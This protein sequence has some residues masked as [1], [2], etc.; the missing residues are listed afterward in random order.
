MTFGTPSVTLKSVSFASCG[1]NH[2][3]NGNIEKP[4]IKA[5]DDYDGNPK[6]SRII[7]ATDCKSATNS[8]GRKIHLAALNPAH[9]R[10]KHKTGNQKQTYADDDPNRRTS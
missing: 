7:C 6:S 2:L 8:R 5:A 3:C 4:R 9:Y 10:K 1:V